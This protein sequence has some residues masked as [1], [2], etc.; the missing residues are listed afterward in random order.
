MEPRGNAQVLSSR[1]PLAEMVG[2]ATELRSVTQGRAS[3]SMQFACYAEVP[4]DAQDE[5]IRKVRGY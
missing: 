3:Y 4:R 5:I 2:Y 1:V